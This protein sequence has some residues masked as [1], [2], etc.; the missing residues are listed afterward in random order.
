VLDSAARESWNQVGTASAATVPQ[1][2]AA[3]PHNR[4]ATSG[5]GGIRTRRESARKPTL[6]EPGGAESGALPLAD[7]S[8]PP[9]LA[10]L[11]DAWPRL[12]EPI[13]A[14]ILSLVRVAST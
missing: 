10:A 2:T 12:P 6:S 9:E 14:G 8:I 3:A 1:P 5:E 11:I 13:R 7:Q 4:S